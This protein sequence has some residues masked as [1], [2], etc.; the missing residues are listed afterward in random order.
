MSI[1]TVNFRMKRTFSAI[2]V[3]TSLFM[4]VGCGGKSANTDSAPPPENND[5]GSGPLSAPV[6]SDSKASLAI[7]WKGSSGAANEIAYHSDASGVKFLCK[8]YKKGDSA[9]SAYE[10]CDKASGT[11]AKFVFPSA[12]LPDGAYILEAIKSKDAVEST[13]LSTELYVHASLDS[14]A[15]CTADSV[16]DE[17]YFAKAS[18]FLPPSVAFGSSTQLTNPAVKVQF[19]SGDVNVLSLRRRFVADANNKLLLI[20]RAYAS[21]KNSSC[22]QN[23]Q[24]GFS[25]AGPGAGRPTPIEGVDCP[26]LVANAAGAAVCLK[27]DPANPSQAVFVRGIRALDVKMAARGGNKM[28]SQKTKDAAAA[29]SNT[30]LIPD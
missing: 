1:Q 29:N 17:T 25:N 9:P 14:V 5:A 18:E 8:F 4:A 20:R 3:V 27:P 6:V 23:V 13:P 2:W 24:T 7:G 19:Q 11:S 10:N 30:L 21:R 28:F 12:V 16:S 26:A 22:V 15:R